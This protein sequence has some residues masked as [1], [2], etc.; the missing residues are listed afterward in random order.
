MKI[1]AHKNENIPI[2]HTYTIYSSN[3]KLYQCLLIFPRS[4]FDAGLI[5]IID[6]FDL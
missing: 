3:K 4:Y 6:L 1:L 5:F 2:K